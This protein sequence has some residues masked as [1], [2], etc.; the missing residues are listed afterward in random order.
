M[1]LSSLKIIN[2]RKKDVARNLFGDFF[3]AIQCT[4]GLKPGDLQIVERVVKLDL[5]GLAVG[6]FD[7]GIDLFAWSE[8]GQSQD[9]DLGCWCDL[10]QK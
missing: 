10:K 6:V 8:V 2:F 7:L 4:A 5:V 9:G 3:H 1:E